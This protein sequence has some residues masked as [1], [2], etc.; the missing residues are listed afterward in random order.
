MARTNA[1]NEV[2]QRAGIALGRNNAFN[3]NAA[4][5]TQHAG[6]AMANVEKIAAIAQELS[7]QTPQATS[8]GPQSGGSSGIRSALTAGALAAGAV[9]APALAPVAAA[10]AA[11]LAISDAVKFSTSHAAIDGGV[12]EMTLASAAQFDDKGD[13]THYTSA[14]DGITTSVGTGKPVAKASI[15]PSGA[16]PAKG[17]HNFSAIVGEV[18]SE[19]D[20]EQ[21][22][23][24]ILSLA[25]Q[26]TDDFGRDMRRLKQ[27]G[28]DSKDPAITNA[29]GFMAEIGQ[30]IKLAVKPPVAPNMGMPAAFRLG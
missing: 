18:A 20:P 25:K 19:V 23:K 29:E 28:M 12:G 15:G 9:F 21:F 5:V 24:D 26:N 10:T 4:S 1:V 11:V 27:M 13:M 2:A 6:D 22:K 30:D 7:D 8:V 17:M 14:C 16:A 3:E